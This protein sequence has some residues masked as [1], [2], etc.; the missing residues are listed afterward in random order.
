MALKIRE[1]K[2]HRP[3][4][5]AEFEHLDLLGLDFCSVEILVA[6]IGDCIGMFVCAYTK[7]K[8]LRNYIILN[9]SLFAN[10]GHE[11]GEQRKI[12]AVHEFCHFIAIV[13]MVT[14]VTLPKVK[15][16]IAQRLNAK[17]DRLSNEAFI[18][19]YALLSSHA[20]RSPRPSGIDETTDQHFRL[21]YEDAALDYYL[22]FR[23]LLFSKDLFETEFDSAKQAEFKKLIKNNKDKAISLLLTSL[24]KVTHDKWVP[25]PFAYEQLLEWVHTYMP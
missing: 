18:E 8:L 24:K 19:L 17:I 20:P 5:F 15:E 7:T 9:S 3:V 21:D 13:Y 1:P 22:L 4:F 2:N 14:S 11:V 10:E 12:T 23:H 16:K 6:D 25:Y